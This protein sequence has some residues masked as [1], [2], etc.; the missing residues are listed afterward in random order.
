ML[1]QFVYI[2][3]GKNLIMLAILF[4]ALAIAYLLLI[5][6]AGVRAGTFGNLASCLAGIVS[7]LSAAL[8]ASIGVFRLI[9]AFRLMI[10]AALV[11]LAAAGMMK[12]GK[13]RPLG[14][15]IILGNYL[16]CSIAGT[17]IPLGMQSPGYWIKT[18]L[19]VG[20]F[21]LFL[22]LADR[23][24]PPVDDKAKKPDGIVI[25]PVGPLVTDMYNNP[26][27]NDGFTAIDRGTGRSFHYSLGE[28][29]DQDGNVVSPGS[30]HAW[31]LDDYY[32]EHIAGHDLFGRMPYDS[33]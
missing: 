24:L 7:P 5:Y 10:E 32:D 14:I 33:K 25:S 3:S 26:Y 19:A 4:A 17:M 8:A 12:S 28:W 18:A 6:K 11:I 15:V 21:G 27:A 16:F 30:A 1:L 31:G 23:D 9:F 20:A 13:K 29:Y 22:L 2:L